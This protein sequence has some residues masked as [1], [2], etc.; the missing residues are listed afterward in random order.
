[1]AVTIAEKVES[2]STS[3]KGVE[4]I[5][6]VSGTTSDIE[7]VSELWSQTASTYSGF[8]KNDARVEPIGDPTI[9][10]MWTGTVSYG[11]PDMNPVREVGD[12]VYSFDTGGGTQHITNALLHINSYAPSGITASD[13]QG[14]I[15]VTGSGAD[16]QVEGVD[17]ISPVYNFAETHYIAYEDVDQDYKLALFN[18]T[19]KVNSDS[20]RGFSAGEVLFLGASGTVRGDNADWEISF[21]FAA[22]KNKTGLTIGTGA[23]KISSIAKKG[24]EYMWVRYKSKKDTSGAIIQI[25]A[26][27]HIEQVYGTEAFSTLGI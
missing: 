11:Q 4:F 22:S 13:W 23:T 9:S 19:G 17:I 20:F 21:R 1:M 26:E 2:R 15:N 6:T 25:P 24:W 5:Y 7:A 27:V 16:M 12:S 8:Y 14:A 10:G 18:A 3:I